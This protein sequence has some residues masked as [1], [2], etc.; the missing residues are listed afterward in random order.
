[1][2]FCCEPLKWA[3]TELLCPRC[4]ARVPPAPPGVCAPAVLVNKETPLQAP[5]RNARGGLE[6]PQAVRAP[7]ISIHAPLFRT[8][9][10]A[11]VVCGLGSAALATWTMLREPLL[12]ALNIEH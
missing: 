7:A 12:P 3:Q 5:G 11:V 4:G 1:M 9:V 6:A 8:I 10:A 2:R